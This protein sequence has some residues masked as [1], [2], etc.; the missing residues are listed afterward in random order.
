MCSLAVVMNA[1]CDPLRQTNNVEGGTGQ[2]ASASGS[3]TG[4][5]SGFGL[6]TR[7]ADG[8]CDENQAPVFEVDN[9]KVRR[10]LS[11]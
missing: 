1:L 6:A 2:F 3:F 4:T 11:L 8:G 10:S 5:V 7:A 9:F